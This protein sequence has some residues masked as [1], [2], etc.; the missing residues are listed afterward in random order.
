MGLCE[1]MR[2]LQCAMVNLFTV[3]CILIGLANQLRQDQG[4]PV[5]L[6]SNN[7][8]RAERDA[9]TAPQQYRI[10]HYVSAHRD[11]HCGHG[12]IKQSFPSYVATPLDDSGELL[13]AAPAVEAESS[14]V[15]SRKSTRPRLRTL[16]GGGSCGG[17]AQIKTKFFK[18]AH[19]GVGL[20]CGKSGDE[21]DGEDPKPK[22]KGGRTPYR[23]SHTKL[24]HGPVGDKWRATV[25]LGGSAEDARHAALRLRKELDR[26][27]RIQKLDHGSS[28]AAPST[29]AVMSLEM[30][31][32]R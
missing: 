14:A 8:L 25:P 6:F 29:E 28:D 13:D 31:V 1:G 23:V 10:I 16:D 27:E 17:S 21:N 26:A 7:F 5:E 15:R 30:G 18:S 20:L 22:G 24:W 4:D 32:D 11:V 2:V 9:K 3:M 12:I 19:V